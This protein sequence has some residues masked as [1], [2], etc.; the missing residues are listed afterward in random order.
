MLLSSHHLSEVEA[1]CD[2]LVFFHG[3]RILADESPAA[4]RARARRSL[5]LAYASADEADAA[6]ELIAGLAEDALVESLEREDALLRLELHDEDPRAFLA[7]L[8]ELG[9]PGPCAVESGRLSLT[10]LYRTV[11]GV[12]GL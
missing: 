11:Y 6:A 10:D 9:G 7:A 12:D 1:V 8:A 3:G 5:R 2:R 4:L